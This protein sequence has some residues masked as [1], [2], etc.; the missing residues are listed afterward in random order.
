M[1]IQKYIKQTNLNPSNILANNKAHF[2]IISSIW[3]ILQVYF[4]KRFGI[5]SDFEAPKYI[6]QGHH[7]IAHGS[8]T[9]NNFIFYS[10]EILLIALGL[11]TGFGFELA[12]S[13]QII[14]NALS[15]YC[16]YKTILLFT[17]S[18]KASLL[19]TI[20][21]LSMIYYHLYNVH[22]FTE[23][24]YYSFTTI[25]AYLLFSIKKLRIQSFIII[26]FCLAL[27]YFTRPT[28]IFFI[29]PTLLYLLLKFYK[30]KT[31]LLPALLII[32]G[33]ILMYFLLNL[34]MKSGGEFDFLLPYS[35]KMIICGVPT[36]D[37]PIA[38]TLPVEKNTLSSLWYL[39]TYHTSLFFN[40]AIKRMLAFWGV[41][42]PFYSLPHNIFIAI[43]FYTLY[44]LIIT[45]IK[46][47]IKIFLPEIAFFLVVVLLVMLT[48]ML[49]CDEW[50]NRF[51]LSLL[52]YLLYLTC[53]SISTNPKQA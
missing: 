16:F 19:F 1:L 28:G 50:H 12:I 23:S 4:F 34:A 38:I 18:Y 51:I 17:G 2:Y 44:F 8:Y 46:Q 42:R 6:E 37:T 21:F 24:L 41:I 52:P 5:V 36:I 40:L 32:A 27:L 11:K 35:S 45:G 13:V 20:V 49:S 39:I 31:K 25:Y 33:I 22:L 30:G 14:I 26:L 43:Y 3:L 10:T 48:S 47:S 53:L 7:F 15:V 29:L 9:S